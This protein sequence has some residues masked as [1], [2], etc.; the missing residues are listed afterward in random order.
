[1][2]LKAWNSMASSF[3]QESKS[4]LPW[5]FYFFGEN[6]LILSSS[7]AEKKTENKPWI[8]CEIHFH[9]CTKK[10][11][12]EFTLNI[13]VF[14]SVSLE[15]IKPISYLW[16]VVQIWPKFSHQNKSVESSWL[17]Y[18]CVISRKK[19]LYQVDLFLLFQCILN[20]LFFFCSIKCRN[21]ALNSHHKFECR[22]ASS[23][24]RTQLNKL[25]LVMASIRAI[26]QRPVEY[27]VQ[28]A[29]QG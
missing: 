2:K 25:P 12:W 11:F 8:L 23:L 13:F 7:W 5:D 18:F 10:S 9:K 16:R 4:F 22:I 6:D 24:E 20:F 14:R 28:E 29:A 27:F 17:R 1:M 15:S 26:T 19:E 3:C 21:E